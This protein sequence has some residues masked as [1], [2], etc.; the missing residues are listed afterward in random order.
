M[1]RDFRNVF[2]SRKEITG[3]LMIVLS[4]GLLAYLGTAFQTTHPDSPEVVVGRVY[5]RDIRRRDLNETMERM[6]QQFGR[7][8]NMESIMPFI[9]Q[10]A[11]GQL[12]N[13]RLTEELANRNGVVVTDAE[14]RDAIASELRSIPFMLDANGQL[15]PTSEIRS[16][17]AQA[18]RMSLKAF[19]DSTRSRLIMSKLYDQAAVLVPVDEVWLEEEHRARNEKM[20]LEYVALSPVDWTVEDPGDAELEGFLKTSGDRF[21]VG[22]RRVLQ[23][24]S[25]DQSFFGNSLV[26]DEEVLKSAFEAKKDSYLELRASHI[27]VMGSTPEELKTAEEK[28]LKIRARIMAG[29]DFARV[30]EAESEDPSAKSNRGDLGWFKDGVMDKGFWDGAVVLNKGE[31]SQPVRSMYGLHLIKMLDRKDRTYEEAK[32][33]LTS[34]ILIE[35]FSARAR[36]RLEQLRKRAGEKGDLSAAASS[37]GLRATTTEPFTFDSPEADGLEGV[38]HA[39][40]DA[41]AMKVGQVSQIISAPGRFLVYRVQRELPIAVPPLKEI[42]ARVL[43]AYRQ[44]RARTELLERFSLAGESLR[45]LGATEI[46]SDYTFEEI[47]ELAGNAL[48][49]R[50]LLETPVGGL[51]KPVWTNEGMLWVARIQSRTAGIPLSFEKRAELAKEIQNKESTKIII[52]EL[53]ELRTKGSMRRGFNSLWGRINGIYINEAALSRQVRADN[54]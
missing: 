22:A 2:K 50:T 11:F 36:E 23:L 43:A 9:Q 49:R 24:V 19:E 34:E 38:G 37:L 7:Q 8:D 53:D 47:T 54:Y 15:L 3:S 13:L 48:A 4:F 27:L 40:H 44:E 41:F 29:A 21:Q 5:G 33:E 30:A 52:A 31:V 20:S 26:P 39:V 10:Q 6:I 28:I 51:T 12:L 14:L 42:R 1:L 32:E 17:L 16:L 25:V 45:T 35:R 18:F 46:K